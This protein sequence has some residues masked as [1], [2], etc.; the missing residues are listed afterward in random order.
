M[1]VSCWRRSGYCSAGLQA[2]T[3]PESLLTL[4]NSR[5]AQQPSLTPSR[6]LPQRHMA[7]RTRTM[8]LRGG[9]A[10]PAA[11]PASK[12]LAALR[13]AAAAAAAALEAAA[14]RQMNAAAAAGAGAGAAGTWPCGPPS[15]TAA[16]ACAPR[17]MLDSSM[18]VGSLESSQTAG[19]LTMDRSYS[20]YYEF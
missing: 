11:T 4:L 15:P 17:P 20:R 10:A 3:E 14:Q 16:D 9:S 6:P 1:P 19:S 5:S 7:L 2:G 12:Q 18:S 8:Q 13:Q